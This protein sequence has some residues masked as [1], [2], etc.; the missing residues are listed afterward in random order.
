MY[1]AQSEAATIKEFGPKSIE[2]IARHRQLLAKERATNRP[3]PHLD[4]KIFA[5]WNGLMISGLV[6]G[7]KAM[8]V[9]AAEA[10]AESTMFLDRAYASAQFIREN[11]LD[12]NGQLY[13]SWRHGERSAIEAFPDDYAFLIQGLAMAAYC[14]LFVCKRAA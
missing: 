7:Y 1:E 10:T 3:L 9:D 12:A 5:S 2:L 14:C 11:M 13:R 8:L 4:D 6:D